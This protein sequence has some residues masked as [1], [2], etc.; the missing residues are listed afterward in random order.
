VIGLSFTFWEILYHCLL[1]MTAVLEKSYGRPCS[2]PEA[3]LPWKAA[4]ILGSDGGLGL[5]WK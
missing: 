4:Y 1:P 5:P 3:F 2:V